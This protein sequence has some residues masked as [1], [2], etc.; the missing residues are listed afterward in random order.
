[1]Q[2]AIAVIHRNVFLGPLANVYQLHIFVF[3]MFNIEDHF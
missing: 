3:N 1:M 2:K